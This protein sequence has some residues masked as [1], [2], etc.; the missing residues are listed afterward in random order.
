MISWLTGLA[1]AFWGK[2]LVSGFS[3]FSVFCVIIEVL[4]DIIKHPGNLLVLFFSVC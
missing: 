2:I 3:V 1:A 4:I